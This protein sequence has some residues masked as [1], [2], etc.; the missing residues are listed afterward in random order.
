MTS[1][2]STGLA[3]SLTVLGL[4]VARAD[5]GA[6]QHAGSQVYKFS[7][8]DSGLGTAD[9]D[10]IAV[11]PASSSATVRQHRYQVMSTG[12]I[13]DMSAL[14]WAQQKNHVYIVLP[15]TSAI[16][17]DTRLPDRIRVTSAAG[18]V[19]NFA[20]GLLVDITDASGG[21]LCSVTFA[22]NAG[23]GQRDYTIANCPNRLVFDTGV[24]TT[25]GA[26]AKLTATTKVT[27]PRGR[28]CTIVNGALF[29]PIPRS[30]GADVRLKTQTQIYQALKAKAD[31]GTLD[32]SSIAR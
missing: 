15:V 2:I 17:F 3:L 8:R 24:G 11:T 13:G 27:D 32:L 28:S 14:N 20:N 16:K 31:C 22:K 18:L 23:P 1:L 26:Y 30:K 12:Q 25:N 10:F 5:E 19:L 9:A 21:H 29:S 7:V 4:N 6:T